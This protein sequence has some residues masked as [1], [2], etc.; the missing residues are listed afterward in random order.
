[1]PERKFYCLTER[2]TGERTVYVYASSKTEA[3]ANAR[4]GEAVG[5]DDPTHFNYRY[6]GPVSEVGASTS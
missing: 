4:N 6:V 1:M 2:Y 3:L 5:E